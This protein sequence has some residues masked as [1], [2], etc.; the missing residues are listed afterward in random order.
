MSVTT[1]AAGKHYGGFQLRFPSQC[2]NISTKK[3]KKVKTK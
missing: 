2:K 3:V 1:A